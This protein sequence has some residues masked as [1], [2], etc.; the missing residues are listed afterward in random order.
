[1]VSLALLFVSAAESSDSVAKERKVLEGTW[2]VVRA[3]EFGKKTHDNNGVKLI[4]SSDTLTIDREGRKFSTRFKLD[5]TTT[6][7]RIDVPQQVNE[8]T[9]LGIY[10]LEGDTMRLCWWIER[11]TKLTSEKGILVIL[12]R[13]P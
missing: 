12:K 10:A 4:F 1:M 8:P 13:A 5:P 3:E 9:V 2:V 7:K 11:P 6:P